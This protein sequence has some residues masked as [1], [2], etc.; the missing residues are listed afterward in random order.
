MVIA[1]HAPTPATIANVEAGNV[2]QPI[3]SRAVAM[4]R[5]FMG[6]VPLSQVSS[7]LILS[8]VVL[9][10]LRGLWRVAAPGTA[11]REGKYLT[12]KSVFL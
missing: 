10:A 7:T 3:A 8:A 5:S 4:A 6:A 1:A 2:S 11:T 12:T 9:M